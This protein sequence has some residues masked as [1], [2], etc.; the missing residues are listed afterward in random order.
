MLLSSHN[1]FLSYSLLVIFFVLHSHIIDRVQ[2]LLIA[3]PSCNYGHIDLIVLLYYDYGPISLYGNLILRL[4]TYSLYDRC[5]RP[6]YSVGHRNHVMRILFFN[7][8]LDI[9][10]TYSWQY[11][12][13][14]ILPPNTILWWMRLICIVPFLKLASFSLGSSK[15]WFHLRST[16]LLYSAGTFYKW[17]RSSQKDA[18]FF[19]LVKYIRQHFFC[20]AILYFNMPIFFLVF[21]KEELG[22]Y[23][24]CS[25]GEWKFLLTS[26]IILS[27][28]F[29][30]KI[31]WSTAYPCD[32]IK[33]KEHNTCGNISSD[34]THSNSVEILVVNFWFLE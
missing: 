3:L 20:G 17:L 9:V 4:W 21:Y 23:M 12:A 1:T 11:C 26:S 2:S 15:G 22:L 14:Q 19:L 16:S 27:I 28:L 25:F 30:Y 18:P 10:V 33:Y 24:L 29:L 6:M 8:F 34:P 32:S 13:P 31:V 7:L 5:I